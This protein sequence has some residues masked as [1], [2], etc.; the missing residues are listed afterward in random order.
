MFSMMPYFQEDSM[1][2]TNKSLALIKPEVLGEIGLESQDDL[3]F[4]KLEKHNLRKILSAYYR[5]SCR[6]N[7]IYGK[8]KV[9]SDKTIFQ[10]F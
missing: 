10:F 2:D 4:D 7:A 5:S 9:K 8:K 3:Y 1:N 6:V